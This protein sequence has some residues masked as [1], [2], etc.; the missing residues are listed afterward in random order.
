MNVQHARRMLENQDRR[1]GLL[2]AARDAAMRGG[3]FLAS[4]GDMSPAGRTVAELVRVLVR[5]ADEV[6]GRRGA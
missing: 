4:E 2:A 1:A 6:E 3:R 5:L